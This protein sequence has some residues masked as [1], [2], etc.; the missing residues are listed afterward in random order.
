MPA[1]LCYPTRS[2]RRVACSLA[3]SR[4]RLAM[5]S[6]IDHRQHARHGHHQWRRSGDASCPATM[7]LG[8]SPAKLWPLTTPRAS[9]ATRWERPVRLELMRAICHRFRRWCCSSLQ[10]MSITSIP[11]VNYR[12]WSLTSRER[13]GKRELH[14]QQ[15][16]WHVGNQLGR[17]HQESSW[18][19]VVAGRGRAAS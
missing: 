3:L 7:C 1:T 19:E 5:P 15:F 10:S 14:S 9:S 11:T 8:A 17:H 16:V 18:K 13:V 2:S 6:E 12:V 4:A